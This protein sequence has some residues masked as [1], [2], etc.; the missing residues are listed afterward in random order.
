MKKVFAMLLVLAMVLCLGM[1]AV[2]ADETELSDRL[3]AQY[4]FDNEDVKD[5]VSID[6]D[7][8]A[9]DWALIR[10]A[11][12]IKLRSKVLDL[13]DACLDGLKFSILVETYSKSRHVTTV[14]TAICKEALERNA[15]LLRTLKPVLVTCS[16]ET[17]HI[18]ETILL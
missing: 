17:S 4:T 13:T 18:H 1:P 14:H 6:K 9:S 12:L 3:I 16:D 8:M 15:V 11:V 2:G 5:S 7:S 10:N